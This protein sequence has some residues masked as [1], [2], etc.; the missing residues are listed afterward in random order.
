MNASSVG[1][2]TS[3]GPYGGRIWALAIDP[4]T[5]ATLYAGTDGGGVFKSTDAGGTWTSANTGLTNLN[6]QALAINPT[7]PATLYAGTYNGGV[8][9]STNAQLP[10]Q[11]GEEDPGLAPHLDRVVEDRVAGEHVVARPA[12][13]RERQ[14]RRDAGPGNGHAKAGSVRFQPRRG[15]PP[16]L[17]AH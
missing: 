9:K 5:P 7:T 10:L 2:W 11:Q 3:A 6:V 12:L 17:D 14:P 16:Q 1:V 4:T 15:S 13:P 8:F